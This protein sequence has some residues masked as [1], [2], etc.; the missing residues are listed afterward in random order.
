MIVK[1]RDCVETGAANV[2]RKSAGPVE[3][4]VRE[5]KTAARGKKAEMHLP[6]RDG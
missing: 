1:E 4:P 5:P 6:E 3:S 2:K